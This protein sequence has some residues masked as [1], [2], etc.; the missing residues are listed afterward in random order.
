MAEKHRTG[1]PAGVRIGGRKAGTPN[2]ATQARD[3]HIIEASAKLTALLSPE[4]IDRMM[5]LDVMLYAVKM[6]LTAGDLRAAALMA[7][8]AAP[9]AHARLTS[10]SSD[11]TIRRDATDFT[12]AE[13]A[14]IA[15]GDGGEDGDIP[16]G[17]RPN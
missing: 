13:L 8:K 6:Y 17:S 9:Y 11:V 12:D 1:P 15:R 7:E 5:P 14:A 16:P 3:Q 10:N 2:K 4:A